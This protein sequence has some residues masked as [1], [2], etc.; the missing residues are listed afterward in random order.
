MLRHPFKIEI[1]PPLTPIL[2]SKVFIE[3]AVNR[4]QR[5][6]RTTGRYPRGEY[7]SSNT[8]DYSTGLFRIASVAKTSVKASQNQ[9]CRT[10]QDS[11]N[12]AMSSARRGKS[13]RRKIIRRKDSDA[14]FVVKENGTLRPQRKFSCDPT[15]YLYQ[16]SRFSHWCQ[17]EDCRKT[18][19]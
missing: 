5:E 10:G 18:T 17:K 2:C 4:N 8:A 9:R 14:S 13:R 12:S 11:S 16:F 15:N 3:Q 7:R 19:D 1:Q 6:I